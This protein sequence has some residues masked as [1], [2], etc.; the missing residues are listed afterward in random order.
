[1][2]VR[3]FQLYWGRHGSARDII[4]KRRRVHD[5]TVGGLTVYWR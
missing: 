3:F 1:M 5:I 2:T 4:A